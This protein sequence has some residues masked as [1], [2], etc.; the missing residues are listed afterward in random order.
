[1][2]WSPGV[3]QVT[4]IWFSGSP[5]I[6]VA[7]WPTSETTRPKKSGQELSVFQGIIPELN[8]GSIRLLTTSL[9]GILHLS[10]HSPKFF[11]STRGKQGGLGT[12]AEINA[13]R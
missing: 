3:I 12:H 9:T 7:T 13:N 1:M 11:I 2:I 4:F 8:G 10:G 5:R 6:C